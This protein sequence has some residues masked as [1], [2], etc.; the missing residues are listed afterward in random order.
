MSIT[1]ICCL[2]ITKLKLVSAISYNDLAWYY[3]FIQVVCVSDAFEGK[4]LIARHRMVNDLL[5]EELEG[6][7]HGMSNLIT[8]HYILS[9]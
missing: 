8:S 3:L 5:K 1:V 7:L 9:S 6:T 4:S 2:H